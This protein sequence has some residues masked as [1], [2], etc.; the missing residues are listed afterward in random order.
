MYTAKIVRKYVQMETK[1]L[2][3]DVEF[4]KDDALFYSEQFAFSLDTKVE[5]VLRRIASEVKRFE[6]VDANLATITIGDLDLSSVAEVPPTAAEI[7][8]QEWFRDFG[9]LEQVQRLGALGAFPAAMQTDL[10]A[11]KTK[12]QTNFKKAYIADM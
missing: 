12:V 10:D 11:L 9:R 2:L 6:A 8:K 5:Q 1:R 3:V 4:C 7:A